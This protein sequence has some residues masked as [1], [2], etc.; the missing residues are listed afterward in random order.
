MLQHSST[1]SIG[2]EV[3]NIQMFLTSQLTS[4]RRSRLHTP[5]EVP[6]SCCGLPAQFCI[7]CCHS[8]AYDPDTYVVCGHCW[9][10]T[11]DLIAWVFVGMQL[12]CQ[13]MVGF[14]DISLQ[15]LKHGAAI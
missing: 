6:E 5:F 14:L 15:Q 2:F 13:C 9:H 7:A 12:Q 4:Q 1:A 3:N 10:M 11:S 8:Y